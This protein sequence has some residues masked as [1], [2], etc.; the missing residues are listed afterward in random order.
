MLKELFV[1][2]VSAAFEWQNDLPYYTEKEY[3]VYLDGREA[4]RGN[5]NV[6]SIFGLSPATEYKITSDALDGE[7]VFSTKA[8]TCAVSVLD[9]GATGDGV[10]DDTVA[11]Q[12]A[13]NCLPKGA[14]LVFPKGT[15]I[16]APLCL[17][18]HITLDLNE[19]ATILGSTDKSKYPIIPGEIPDLDGGDTVHFGSWEGNAVKM[20][21]ALIFAAH[22]ED[23]TIVG[24]GS[25]DGNA[26]AAGWW[27]DVKKYP[28]GR[29][30]LMFF[31]RCDGVHIH[32]VFAANSASWQFHPYFTNPFRSCREAAVV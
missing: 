28:I 9:F 2:S 32:G 18:S 5:T 15:Y 29:P 24:P 11:V 31:N 17:K 3:T 20:H 27:I 1:S 22:A 8:E 12:A 14:R 21:Q 4:Y 30:R 23:I 26:G 19:G 16:T 7:L 25:I 6:F 13:I 10:T